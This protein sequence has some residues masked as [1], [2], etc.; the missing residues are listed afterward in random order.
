M[1]EPKDKKV[2]YQHLTE[3][4]NHLYVNVMSE[5][6]G[7]W[8]YQHPVAKSEVMRHSFWV[9]KLSDKCLTPSLNCLNNNVQDTL[10][11][12]TVVNIVIKKINK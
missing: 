11:L 2:T 9:Q 6:K 4:T 3:T 12:D 7:L 1:G 8:E 5:V 10:S